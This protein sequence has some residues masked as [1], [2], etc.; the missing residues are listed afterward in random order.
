MSENQKYLADATLAGLARWLRLLGYDTA[1]FVREAGREMLRKATSE[2][3]IVLTKRQDMLERQFA[4]K[5]YLIT[6]NDTGSQLQ[7]VMAKFSLKTEKRR[8]FQIC[9]KCNVRLFA[10]GKEEVRDLVPTYV[11]AQYS[12]FT[13]CPLCDSIYWPGTHQRNS[14]Q[15]LEKLGIHPV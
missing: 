6:G 9:L 14:L 13:K 2:Q 3:R 15:F 4:G 5:L 12:E 7:E 1:V 8:M 10:V 11:F